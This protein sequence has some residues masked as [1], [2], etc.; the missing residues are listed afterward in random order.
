VPETP[1]IVIVEVPVVAVLL[2]VKVK[3]LVEVVGLVPKEA[4]TPEGRADV[5]SDTLPVNPP[6]GVTLI[7]EL[8]LLP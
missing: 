6:D 8:P 4:V 3:T 1:V 7:V 2:A 5:E